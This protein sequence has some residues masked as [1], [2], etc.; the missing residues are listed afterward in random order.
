MRQW[1][2][3]WVLARKK[4]GSGKPLTLEDCIK[5]GLGQIGLDPTSFYNLTLHEFILAAEGFH[6]LEEVRQQAD[7]ERTRWL[8]TLML[9]PHAKK[10][11]SIKPRDLAIFPWEKKPKKNKAHA[12]MLR[13]VLKGHSNGKT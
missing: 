7:W 11:Q 3:C 1:P 8:A 9:S 2:A 10:G 4:K 13:Q 12:N 6:K 5:V